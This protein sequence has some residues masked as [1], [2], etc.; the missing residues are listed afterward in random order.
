MNMNLS[1]L[2][3]DT[4][5]AKIAATA[6]ALDVPLHP[7]RPWT[8]ATGE[9]IKGIRTIWNF[10]GASIDG[11]TIG[12][13]TK[14]WHDE[15]WISANQNHEVARIKIA[16]AEL[17]KLADTAKGK[18]WHY[19]PILRG[20]TVSSAS[21]AM[22]AT[23]IALGHPCKGF[24]R[25]NECLFWHFDRAAA[26][27]MALWSDHNLHVK[28]PSTMISYIKCAL[29]NWKT[30]LN[31][32]TIPEYTAVKHGARTAFVSKNDTAKTQSTLEKLLYRK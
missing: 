9:G 11:N 29:L 12:S 26:S 7:D 18:A 16:F 31:E 24:T 8:V 5:N 23:L 2:E 14:A 3:G 13:I 32:C 1:T 17:S 19:D 28:L 6:I 22:A 15:K 30:L 10:K 20:D 27:D 25:G 21:T 4:S